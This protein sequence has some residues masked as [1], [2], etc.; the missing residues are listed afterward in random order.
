MCECG[1]GAGRESGLPLLEDEVHPRAPASAP[2]CDV[3]LPPGGG[4]GPHKGH[5]LQ[6]YPPTL[7]GALCLAS[8]LLPHFSQAGKDLTRVRKAPAW[9]GAGGGGG[10][11]R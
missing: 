5:T 11:H 10:E 6:W 4:R 2:F 1:G 3:S 9:A 7:H 8:H